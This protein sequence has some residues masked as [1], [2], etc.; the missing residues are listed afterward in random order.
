M[1]S[2]LVFELRRYRLQP[3]TRETLIA[4][5]ER[6]LVHTQEAAGMGVEGIYR[7]LDDPDA[8]V[9]FRSFDSMESRAMALGAFYGGP[10]WREH[11]AAANAT[12]VNSDNVLLLRPASSA[13]Q[14]FT[15]GGEP[16]GRPSLSGSAGEHRGLTTARGSR[17]VVTV[18]TASLA[19]GRAEA[20]AAFFT[21]EAAPLLIEAGAR[22]DAAFVTETSPNT[23]QRLPV[24]EGETV[25]VWTSAFADTER[26]EEHVARLGRSP[27]WCDQVFPALDRQLWRPLET[28]RL[29]PTAGSRHRW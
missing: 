20:F 18:S 14:P 24:R 7:D 11:G 4:L 9:W 12:M 29:E 22:I 23:F 27:H 26:Y 16:L 6:E 8:F 3:A 19:P 13:A 10:V 28:A 5:F 21:T 25:F 1:S 17:G 2:P 15:A